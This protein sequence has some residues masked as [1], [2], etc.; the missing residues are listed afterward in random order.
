MYVFHQQSQGVAFD[1]AGG[2]GYCG[3]SV[4]LAEA[5]E[6]MGYVYMPDIHSSLTVYLE[7]SA[8]EVPSPRGKRGRQPKQ[9]KPVI[10]GIRYRPASDRSSQYHQRE[11]ERRLSLSNG[12]CF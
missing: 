1:Y 8:I 11:I 7:A 9:A 10:N 12:V 6:E 2:E 5:I 4:E 3:N